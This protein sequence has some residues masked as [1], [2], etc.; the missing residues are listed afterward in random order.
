MQNVLN[1]ENRCFKTANPCVSLNLIAK[2]EVPTLSLQ[3]D[4][5]TAQI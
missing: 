5:A 3:P 4:I 2:S 1:T